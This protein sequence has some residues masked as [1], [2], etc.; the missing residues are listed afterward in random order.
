MRS[1]LKPSREDEDL[2]PAEALA[3]ELVEFVREPGD[4]A[5]ICASLRDD[6]LLALQFSK[7]LDMASKLIGWDLRAEMSE[8]SVGTMAMLS[9]MSMGL[10]QDPRGRF[11]PLDG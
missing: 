11:S 5:Y 3:D 4:V 1:I 7:V 9:F 6:S 8:Y 10:T 2:T